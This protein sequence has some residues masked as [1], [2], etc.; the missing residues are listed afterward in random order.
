MVAQ[1]CWRGCLWR[2]CLW[3][4]PR[5]SLRRAARI[6]AA[7]AAAVGMVAAYWVLKRYNYICYN[8]DA[9]RVIGKNC[10]LERT[11]TKKKKK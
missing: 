1:G 4:R 7:A 10:Y 9:Q 11:T 3:R 8:S 2:G 5:R 6:A